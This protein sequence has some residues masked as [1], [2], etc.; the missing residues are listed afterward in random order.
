M[1][2]FFPWNLRFSVRAARHTTTDWPRLT[3]T[4]FSINGV[5]IFK[6]LQRSFYGCVS[7]VFQWMVFPNLIH[8]QPFFFIIIF[9]DNFAFFWKHHCKQI[10]TKWHFRQRGSS[11]IV[12]SNE[13]NVTL[14]KTLHYIFLVK[15]PEQNNK[16]EQRY[17]PS[18]NSSLT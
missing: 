2:V 15:K 5:T 4:F 17:D 13:C 7:S 6:M 9:N 16:R 10:V 3:R 11:L 18:S 14:V 12:Y 8:R 1:R